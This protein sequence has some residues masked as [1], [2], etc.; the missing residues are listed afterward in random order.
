MANFLDYCMGKIERKLKILKFLY[1][2]PNVF[3][4]GYSLPSKMYVKKF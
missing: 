2:L 3:V 1:F 4:F